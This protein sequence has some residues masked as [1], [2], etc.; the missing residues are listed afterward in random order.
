MSCI[1]YLQIAVG[2][3]DV[4][5]VVLNPDV[6]V[7]PSKAS[8]APTPSTPAEARSTRGVKLDFKALSGS[9]SSSSEVKEEEREEAAQSDAPVSGWHKV[10]N[11]VR[12]PQA[13]GTDT[14]LCICDE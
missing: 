5:R 13:P 9:S 14:S 7:S 1:T 3:K 10:L 4:M 12:S 6:P 2:K 8:A 11:M